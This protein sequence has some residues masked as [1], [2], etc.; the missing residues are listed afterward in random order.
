MKAR[1]YNF[2][3]KLYVH[4]QYIVQDIVTN[5]IIPKAQNTWQ[6]FA[7]GLFNAFLPSAKM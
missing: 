2:V 4:L 1:V 3:Q 7:L 6:N 5:T